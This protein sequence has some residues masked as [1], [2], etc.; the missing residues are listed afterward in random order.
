MLTED[1]SRDAS[2]FGIRKCQNK[3]VICKAVK[4]NFDVLRVGRWVDLISPGAGFGVISFEVSILFYSP[5]K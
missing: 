3:G 5:F 2:K 1:K 4:A